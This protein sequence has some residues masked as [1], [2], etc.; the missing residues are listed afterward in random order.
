MVTNTSSSSLDQLI[1][2]L[3]IT[4]ISEGRKEEA[5]P[6]IDYLKKKKQQG[7]PIQLVF[8][9]THNSRRSH[10]AQVWGKVMADQYGVAIDSYS[11]GMEV[12]ECNPRTI[13][14]LRNLGFQITQEGDVNP[15]YHLKLPKGGELELFSKL[16]DDTYNPQVNFAA[17]M[18]CSTADANCPFV[19]GAEKRIPLRFDD[20]SE[21]DNTPEELEGYNRRSLE[22]ARE[23]KYI[24]ES[25]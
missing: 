3:D 8:V 24:F 22:I 12:T 2:S 20:P 9:C 4:T 16:Y 13:A 19:A 25:L 6:L 23:L 1:S 17:I 7:D 15:M 10:L 18:V 11:G 5:A 21:F 14:S